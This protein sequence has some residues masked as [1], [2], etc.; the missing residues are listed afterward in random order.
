[1]HTARRLPSPK[2]RPLRG[3]AKLR[4]CLLRRGRRAWART[5]RG[6]AGCRCRLGC[7]RCWPRCSRC[8][9]GCRLSPG[10]S[11]LLRLRETLGFRGAASSI[12]R[13]VGGRVWHSSDGCWRCW[14]G[15]WL[16]G[17]KLG[18]GRRRR[19]RSRSRSRSG[20]L[21]L[22]AALLLRRRGVRGPSRRLGLWLHRMCLRGDCG[23]GWW[24][25]ISV[26][27]C[28]RRLIEVRGRVRK[29]S[30]QVLRHLR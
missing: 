29:A 28:R 11:R 13:S 2:R 5:G 12:S 6:G 20:G 15:R 8:G 4:A 27:V 17:T 23:G 26:I 19:S 24:W 7:W 25:H 1:M 14:C 22:S 9:R 30:E 18:C 3:I 16:R 21:L 10:L